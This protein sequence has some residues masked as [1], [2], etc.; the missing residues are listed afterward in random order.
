MKAAVDPRVHLCRVDAL[1]RSISPIDDIRAVAKI[2]QI[3]RREDID[4]VHTHTSKAGVIGRVAAVL[5]RRPCIIHGVHIL[6]FH[7]VGTVERAIYVGV[8]RALARHTD[9]FVCVSA[10]VRDESLRHGIGKA[11]QYHVV[12]SGMD[13]DRFRLARPLDQDE[14]ASDL[15]HETPYHEIIL[16]VGALE[17]RKRH[18]DVVRAFARFAALH[19]SAVLVLAGSG[20]LESDLRQ[21]IGQLGMSKRV[22]LIGFRNDI[23]RWIASASICVSASEREGLPRVLVQYALACKPIVT[24]NLPGVQEVVQHRRTGFI[25]ETIDDLGAAIKG[26]LADRAARERMQKN[27]VN[28]DLE[29]WGVDQMAARIRTIYDSICHRPA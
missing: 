20:P 24:S 1:V 22:K 10:G 26:L 17:R 7:G 28:L 19:P 15:G 27:S 4:V 13:L 21:V 9:A 14:L 25:T 16:V 29:A 18:V 12:P 6:P 8:E 11:S 2:R 5:E 3:I 23:E